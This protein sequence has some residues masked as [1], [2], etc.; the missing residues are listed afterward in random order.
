MSDKRKR[1]RDRAKASAGEPPPTPSMAV[2][3]RRA[4]QL[5]AQTRQTLRQLAAV[6]ETFAAARELY[7]RN[8]MNPGT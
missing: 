6:R 4:K 7:D 5:Q 2:L 3:L 1:R 8:R